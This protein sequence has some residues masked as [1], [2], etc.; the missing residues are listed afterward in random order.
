MAD[1]AGLRGFLVNIVACIAL[2]A[3]ARNRLTENMLV[4]LQAYGTAVLGSGIMT[5]DALA[6]SKA[7]YPDTI[8]QQAGRRSWT[9]WPN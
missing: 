4:A 9:T 3:S 5:N 6:A 1:H 8:G 7:G 2:L